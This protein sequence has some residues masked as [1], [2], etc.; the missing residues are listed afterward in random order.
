MK[1]IR[2]NW[3]SLV[4]YLFVALGLAWYLSNDSIKEGFYKELDTANAS[5]PGDD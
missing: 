1:E 2:F 5:P 3:F 4:V